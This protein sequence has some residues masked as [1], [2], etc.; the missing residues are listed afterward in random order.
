MVKTLI[1]SL[2]VSIGACAQERTSIASKDYTIV[3]TENGEKL[4]VTEITL[5]PGERF[6]GMSGHSFRII[7]TVPMEENQKPRTIR[8]YGVFDRKLRYI[9]KE[10]R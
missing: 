3:D 10:W 8:I 5:P 6:N 2:L 7:E 9:I 1:L 4:Y